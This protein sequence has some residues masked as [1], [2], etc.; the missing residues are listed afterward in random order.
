MHHLFCHFFPLFLH[1]QCINLCHSICSY[2]LSPCLSK[3]L[4]LLCSRCP[5]ISVYAFSLFHLTFISVDRSDPS[6]SDPSHFLA[7]F[8]VAIDKSLSHLC[9]MHSDNCPSCLVFI[10]SI[11]VTKQSILYNFL[12]SGVL[13]TPWSLT[14]SCTLLSHI[15]TWHL[16]RCPQTC[17]NI[18]VCNSYGVTVY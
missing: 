7:S 11:S 17:E 1:I 4:I 12:S 3:N 14:G 18:L 5:V 13:Q 10:L 6:P 2:F 16:L 8:F 15:P 9:F